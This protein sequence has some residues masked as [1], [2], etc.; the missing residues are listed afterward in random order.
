MAGPPVRAARLV[1]AYALDAVGGPAR[2]RVTL[3]LAAVLGLSGADTGT[4]SAVASNLEHTFGIGNTQIGLLLSAVALAGA[5]FTIPAGIA[6]DRTRRTR[7]LAASIVL[8]AAA[9][10][11]SGAP[12]C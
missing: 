8:W 2:G 7:L 5:V 3:T 6:A 11:A 4:I 10:A 9:M 12:V 1:R